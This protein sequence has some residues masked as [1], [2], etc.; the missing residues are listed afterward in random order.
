M[1]L[2]QKITRLVTCIVLISSYALVGMSLSTAALAPADSC[3]KNG[4]TPDC[5][6]QTNMSISDPSLTRVHS[7]SDFCL[8]ATNI[9][10]TAIFQ[11]DG[12]LVIYQIR[13]APAA[14]YKVATW[15]TRTSGD[16]GANL[17]VLSNG[18]FG[19]FKTVAGRSVALW[20]TGT[21]G[22][23][24]DRLV[25]GDNGLLT[26]YAKGGNTVLWRS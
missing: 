12:N 15:Q 14:F 23:P 13:S 8:F 10:Y 9:E 18:N 17:Q 3:T 19:I 25:M 11:K 21:T 4:T 5:Y 1:A 16:T 26:V 2:R 24:G 6:C 7:P 20:Q 22:H